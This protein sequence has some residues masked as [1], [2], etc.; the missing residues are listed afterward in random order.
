M[1][2]VFVHGVPETLHVWDRLRAELS[3]PSIALALPGF[4]TP[5]PAGFRAI[6]DGYSDWLAE[7]LRRIEGPIDLV[8]HDWGALLSLRVATAYDVPLRSWAVDVASCFHS[9]Y[10]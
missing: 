3:E 9:E 4:G 5:L 2:K 10:V 6:K 1:A 8:G 7:Q